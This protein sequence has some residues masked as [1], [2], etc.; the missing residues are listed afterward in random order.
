LESLLLPAPWMK[1]RVLLIGDAVHSTT[2]QLAQGAAMAIEDA[3]L[4]GELLGR[5]APLPQLLEEFMTRR[6]ARVKFVV[7]ASVQIGAWELEE[8]QGVHNPQANP[9]GLLHS[10]TLALMKDF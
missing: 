10:A 5:D 3:V 6:F 8:W 4:L 9:G 2:P 7:D 1:G